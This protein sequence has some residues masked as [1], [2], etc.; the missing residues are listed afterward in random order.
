[1]TN[2]S[3]KATKPTES[4][5]L[6]PTE[7]SSDDGPKS[8]NADENADGEEIADDLSEISDEADDILGQQ[9]VRLDLF[10]FAT[11]L[12]FRIILLTQKKIVSLKD[13]NA[14]SQQPAEAI[15]AEKSIAEEPKVS[16]PQSSKETNEAVVEKSTDQ[17]DS[18][19]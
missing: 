6:T 10:L 9:E 15:T 16:T 7:K 12:I 4:Q 18:S 3:A 5:P 2:K 17:N 8:T 14:K 13:A 1:M 11:V 19:A